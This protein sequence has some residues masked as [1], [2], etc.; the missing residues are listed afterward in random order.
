MKKIIISL[1]AINVAVL[2]L[3]FSM[4][5]SQVNADVN[6][7]RYEAYWYDCY[8]EIPEIFMANRCRSGS[9]YVICNIGPCGNM[10]K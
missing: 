6:P 2:T 3:V 4:M 5:P 1:F 10:L 8:P 9:D 7:K